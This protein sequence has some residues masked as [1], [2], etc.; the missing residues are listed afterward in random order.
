MRY[1]YNS[2]FLVISSIFGWL[3][4]H[5][6]VPFWDLFAVLLFC[7]LLS[8]RRGIIPVSS[9]IT[10]SSSS[11]TSSLVQFDVKVISRCYAN[12]SAFSLFSLAH[13]PFSLTQ[14]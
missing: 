8:V 5:S 11:S 12:S 9:L 3:L 10:S 4:D 6:L 14:Q 1:L 2:F 7:Q 13:V